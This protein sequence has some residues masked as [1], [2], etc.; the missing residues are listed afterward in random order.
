MP[1]SLSK[2]LGQTAFKFCYVQLVFKEGSS[3][4]EF[5]C[6]NLSEEQVLEILKA[7][8]LREC[9]LLKDSTWSVRVLMVYLTGISTVSITENCGSDV[10]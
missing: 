8:L 2:P 10:A 5:H 9:Y 3:D 7:T 1:C 4:L 6:E